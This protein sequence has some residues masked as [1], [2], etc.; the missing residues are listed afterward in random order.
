MVVENSA[1][2]SLKELDFSFRL[3][4]VLF[5]VSFQALIMN[6]CFGRLVK[7]IIILLRNEKKTSCLI[8]ISMRFP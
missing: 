7:L 3:R 2:E 6:S 8:G 4:Q 1:I 5:L